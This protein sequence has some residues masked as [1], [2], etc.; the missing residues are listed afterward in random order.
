MRRTVSAARLFLVLH[1]LLIAA[2]MV[3]FWFIVDRP[4]PGWVDPGLWMRSYAFGMQWTGALYIVTGFLAATAG[5]IAVAGVRRGLAGAAAVVLLS[6]GIEL[7]GV[8]TGFP[9]GG[10]AYGS[11]LGPRVLGLVPFVIPLSWFMMLYA[12]L[13][14]AVRFGRGLWGTAVI[15]SLGLVAWDVLMDPA[16]SVAFP[17]WSWN[18]SGVYFGMPLVNWAGWF[19]TG[20]VIALPA[21]ALAGYRPLES[22]PAPGTP[23]AYREPSTG[24]AERLR[25][26]RLPLY[27]YALNGLFPFALALTK[28]MVGA[29]VI[30]GFVMTAFLL[31]PLLHSPV[32]MPVRPAVRRV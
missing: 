20:V 14:I 30:G 32:P 15:A 2:S 23:A 29:A 17:F 4:V 24:L 27:L 3:A 12:S 10:Y 16:M 13:A 18:T 8:A 11:A 28:G 7:M 26:Q 19:F 22:G 21:L 9:F 31:S 6:L 1:A 25:E 5:W